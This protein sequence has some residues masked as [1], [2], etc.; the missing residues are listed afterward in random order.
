M[1][2]LLFDLDGTLTNPAP[3]IT[4][5]IAY[6]LEKLGHPIPDQA[7][8][9]SFIGPPLRATFGALLAT[10]AAEPIEVAIRL[11]RERFADVGLFENSPYPGIGDLLRALMEGGKKAVVATSKPHV[12][13][14]RIVEHFGFTPFIAGVYGPELDGTNDSKA[15][16]VRLACQDF[17][18]AT[19]MVGDRAVDIAAGQAMGL[20]T[21]AV[22]YGFGS[23]AELTAAQPSHVVENVVAL[24]RLCV[25]RFA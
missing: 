6:A 11:Y 5:S 4:R 12:Y 7:T 1:A 16:I 8:L 19:T 18:D 23:V 25:G 24:R 10:N 20:R 2:T 14:K 22:T 13:A 15:M 17:G 9:E 21:V 3:G